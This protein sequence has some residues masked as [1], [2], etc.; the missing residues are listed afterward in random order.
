MSREVIDHILKDQAP[1]CP[2]YIYSLNNEVQIKSGN[3]E[4][5]QDMQRELL[6][7]NQAMLYSALDDIDIVIPFDRV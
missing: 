5:N 3:D 7:I 6:S 2:V 4:T 1:K